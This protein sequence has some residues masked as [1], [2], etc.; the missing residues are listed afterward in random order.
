MGTKGKRKEQSPKDCRDCENWRDVQE[1][2]R[3][4]EALEKAIKAIETKINSKDFNP[5]M[6]EYLKLIQVEKD[7]KQDDTKEIRITWV[8]AAVK[9]EPEK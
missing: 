3:V 2:V 6:A 1:R 5:T 9:P 7:L 4:S 8:E